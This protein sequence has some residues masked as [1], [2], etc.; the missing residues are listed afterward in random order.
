MKN[1]SKILSAILAGSLAFGAVGASVGSVMAGSG[2]GF[3]STVLPIQSISKTGL[4]TLV[5]GSTYAV[6][7]GFDVSTLKVGERVSI[8]WTPVKNST[9]RDA[10]TISVL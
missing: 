10:S 4:V 6:P 8:I 7:Y 3:Q 9:T 2:R 1:R 5:D